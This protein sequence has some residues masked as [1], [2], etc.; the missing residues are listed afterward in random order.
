MARDDGPELDIGLLMGGIG[1]FDKLAEMFGR[2]MDHPNDY[3]RGRTW[4]TFH[5]KRVAAIVPV[6]GRA[7]VDKPDWWPQP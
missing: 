2:A 3:Q 5:G 6:G 4:L 7:P 1:S